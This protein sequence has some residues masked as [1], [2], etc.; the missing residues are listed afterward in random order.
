[1]PQDILNKQIER[2]EEILAN[3]IQSSD[4][5]GD[6]VFATHLASKQI[7]ASHVTDDG[8]TNALLAAD[9][10]Q[11]SQIAA[12][13]VVD[14]S[15][16]G[17]AVQNTHLA[18]D[19]VDT[20]QIIADA[21]EATHLA[22]KVITSSHIANTGVTTG[23]YVTGDFT[24]GADG[25]LTVASHGATGRGATFMVA[26]NDANARVK[27]Q[28]DYLCD[29]TADEV[30][31]N[32][33][34]ADLP[35]GGGNIILS[36]GEFNFANSVRNTTLDS[37]TIQGQGDST[38]IKMGDVQETTL[39]GAA[40]LGQKDLT[41]HD[42]SIFAVGMQIAICTKD[43][44]TDDKDW[45][46]IA[47]IAGNTIT[48]ED[49]LNKNHADGDAVY[50]AFR[51]FEAEGV[52]GCKFK[53]FKINGNNGN[54][55]YYTQ[56]NAVTYAGI[57]FLAQNGIDLDTCTNCEVS[58]VHGYDLA[59]WAVAVCHSGEYNKI[60]HSI[61]HD[62]TNHGFI[63]FSED[64]S[65]FDDCFSYDNGNANTALGHGF[66]IENS[67]Y[68]SLTGGSISLGN[69]LTGIYV[70]TTG[71]G[72]MVDG[73]TFIDNGSTG[74]R[75]ATNRTTV[76]GNV[77]YTNGSGEI[78]ISGSRDLCT[79]TGNTIYV[80]NDTGA[81][82]T[83]RGILWNPG[84]STING[85]TIN[86]NT[87]YVD[88]IAYQGIGFANTINNVSCNNNT[89]SG[90]EITSGAIGI[91]GTLGCDGKNVKI[92][93]N[94]MSLT[95]AT[96]GIFIRRGPFTHSSIEGNTIEGAAI[97]KTGAIYFYTT[98]EQAGWK[99]ENLGVES[100]NDLLAESSTHIR[101][102]E[103]MSQATTFN[104]TIDAHPDTPRTLKFETTHAN[105]TAYTIE[106]KGITVDGLDTREI[107]EEFT[108]ADGWSWE[109]SHAYHYITFVRCTARTGTGVGDTADVGI[110][111]KIGLG[112]K[113]NV[114]TDIIKVKK[115][116]ADYTGDGANVTA[117]T[118]YHTLDLSTGGA[119][120]NGDD[121]T[122]WVRQ[123]LNT[124]VP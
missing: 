17:N 24:V 42:I 5:A 53:D 78:G 88:G 67:T 3:V 16:A 33:A 96:Y 18:A 26:A 86:N 116:N 64:K 49:N 113:I 11:T 70:F 8:I 32:S 114:A 90:D 110:G 112:Q 61:A 46:R 35:A 104:F 41:V 79:V 45:G 43:Y 107:V 120:V 75:I 69:Y 60:R 7:T 81:A 122:V 124:I 36:E 1:M 4:I 6:Q 37:V 39:D 57:I 27:N 58:G 100:H 99:F 29:G 74:I 76:T 55:Y 80:Y 38:V 50:T 9:S 34:I 48:M 30:Q 31:I 20:S 89:I 68:C 115:N 44:T 28:A 66:C 105:I 109:T 97:P 103:D 19:S 92:N 73:C 101:N 14:S 52:D 59:G 95:T 65:G 22:S 93:D 87:I 25:R 47:S 84:T 12:G 72:C 10:I 121:F 56:A 83:A 102:G 111:S 118:T 123:A 54:N 94:I 98:D 71:L 82:G 13:N 23:S 2:S 108:E 91:G 106:V 63:L 62:G 21:V 15:I 85:L 51:L 77:I 117:D 119:I 40:N